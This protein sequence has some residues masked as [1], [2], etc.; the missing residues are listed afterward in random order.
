MSAQVPIR[1][2]GPGFALTVL[3]VAAAVLVSAPTAL[4]APAASALSQAAASPIAA[5]A[6]AASQFT[7]TPVPTIAGIPQAGRRLTASPGTWKPAPVA[8]SYR[9]M[10]GGVTVPGATASVFTPSNTHVGKRVTVTVT[11]TKAGYQTVSK[12]SAPTRLVA[13]ATIAVGAS[14]RKLV[15]TADGRWAYVANSGAGTV[16]VISAA[17]GRVVATVPVG[18]NPIGLAVSANQKQL[19]VSSCTDLKV[20]AVN[21]ASNTVAY[22]FKTGTCGDLVA[23]PDGKSLYIGN[24]P[25]LT[26][27]TVVTIASRSLAEPIFAFASVSELTPSADQTKVY[28]SNGDD[29]SILI[30]DTATNR[31]LTNRFTTSHPPVAS[32]PSPDGKTVY[33]SLGRDLFTGPS[34]A[35][36]VIDIATNRVR[37]SIAINA[38]GDLEVSP[39]GSK[40]YVLSRDDNTIVTVS[41][42]TNRVLSR[43]P[44]GRAPS[45]LAVT[46]DGRKVGIVNS[47]DNT[48]SVLP[49][50]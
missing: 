6:G 10:V 4:A 27:I 37:A 7:A 28:V 42:A 44:V 26:E 16:S 35:V 23:T 1:Q 30:V 41:T 5:S 17:T 18:G 34:N 19:F 47:G 40:L 25:T 31:L 48:V 38:P 11:G 33:A 15:V 32:A 46:P 45:S 21:I 39:D 20:Y 2:R 13:P 12:A 3:T 8:L 22:S 9:W 36:E 49:V 24:S 14:P 29:Y 50:F 43:I